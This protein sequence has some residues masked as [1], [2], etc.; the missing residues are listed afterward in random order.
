MGQTDRKRQI[1]SDGKMY[2]LTESGLERWKYTDIYRKKY[3]QRGREDRQGETYLKSERKR[4]TKRHIC[5]DGVK[6]ILRGSK[7]ETERESEIETSREPTK[8]ERETDTTGDKYVLTDGD[9]DRQR[10]TD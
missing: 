8:T 1:Y 5:K 10:E 6:N 9:K 2:R 4:Q 3:L 7:I